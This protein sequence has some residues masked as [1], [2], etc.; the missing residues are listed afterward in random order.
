M[1]SIR[2]QAEAVKTVWANQKLTAANLRGNPQQPAHKA[3]TIEARLP[4]LFDAARTL[5]DLATKDEAR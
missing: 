1:T 3:E 2:H 5:H 4:A